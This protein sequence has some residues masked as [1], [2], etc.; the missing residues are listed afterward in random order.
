MFNLQS[1]SY[2]NRP[3]GTGYRD[4][5]PYQNNNL[6]GD[7]K[8]NQGM[9]ADYLVDPL[10]VMNDKTRAGL[11]NDMSMNMIA[12]GIPMGFGG[13]LNGILGFGAPFGGGGGGGFLGGLL[14]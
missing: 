10:Y 1:P 6:P 12:P 4:P 5:S 8:R 9:I 13:N 14:G 7:F 11:A 3:F 2:G